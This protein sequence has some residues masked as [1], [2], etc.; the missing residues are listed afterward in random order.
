VTFVLFL[1]SFLAS[2]NMLTKINNI[3]NMNDYNSNNRK[4][5]P[6]IISP[7]LPNNWLSYCLQNI[8]LDIMFKYS[9]KPFAGCTLN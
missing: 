2:E 9:E 5:F 8:L 7:F 1:T 4:F 3:L 6:L